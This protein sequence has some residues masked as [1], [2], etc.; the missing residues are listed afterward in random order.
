MST[1]FRND[2]KSKDGTVGELA[3]NQATISIIAILAIIQSRTFSTSEEKK[4]PTPVA[5]TSKDYE[6]KFR[7]GRSV[8]CS[9]VENDAKKPEERGIL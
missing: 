7:I 5:S 9:K 6:G 1:K 4:E 3:K 8:S 2:S